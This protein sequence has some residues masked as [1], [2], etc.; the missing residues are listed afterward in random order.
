MDFDETDVAR[1]FPVAFLGRVRIS[2]IRGDSSLLP[3]GPPEIPPGSGGRSKFL[4]ESLG[5]LCLQLE[6]LCVVKWHLVG[7]P[8]LHPYTCLVQSTGET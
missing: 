4:P 2:D 8:A 5:P 1:F 7:H 6:V 3:A